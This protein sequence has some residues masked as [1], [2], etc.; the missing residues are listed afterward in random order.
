MLP[1]DAQQREALLTASLAGLDQGLGHM[2]QHTQSELKNLLGLLTLPRRAPCW[3][4][5]GAAGPQPAWPRPK[6]C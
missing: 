1:A 3:Q 5:A 2:P 4:V 6:P